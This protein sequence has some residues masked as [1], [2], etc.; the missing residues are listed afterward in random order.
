MRRGNPTPSIVRLIRHVH[1]ERFLSPYWSLADSMAFVAV[2]AD[3]TGAF[4]KRELL[5]P[6]T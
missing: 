1:T 6:P 3:N 2:E 4:T 5:L